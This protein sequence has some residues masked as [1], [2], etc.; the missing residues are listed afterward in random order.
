MEVKEPSLLPVPPV[1]RRSIVVCIKSEDNGVD[2]LDR[3]GSYKH[4]RS[5]VE[6]NC[7]RIY[8]R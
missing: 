2:K 7:P 5:V 1:F 6:E 4:V 8:I 3:T